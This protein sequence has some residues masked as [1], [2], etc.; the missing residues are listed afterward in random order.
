VRSVKDFTT[1]KERGGNSGHFH[2]LPFRAVEELG[3]VAIIN[4][5]TLGDRLESRLL[6]WQQTLIENEEGGRRLNWISWGDI[7]PKNRLQKT[8]I[9]DNVTFKLP[10]RIISAS[11]D[12]EQGLVVERQLAETGES[13]SITF[14]VIITLNAQRATTSTL[15]TSHGASKTSFPFGVGV[16]SFVKYGWSSAC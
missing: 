10:L 13:V 16:G 8:G 3:R 5:E 12:R 14:K 9:E 1:D 4:R 7:R 15:S 6:N 2:L 11:I